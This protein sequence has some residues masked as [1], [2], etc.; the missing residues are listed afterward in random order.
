MNKLKIEYDIPKQ[1]DT[2]TF[3]EVDEALE[4]ALKPFGYKRWASGF[5]LNTRIRDLAFDKKG[6]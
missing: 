6:E 1:A 4:K 2:N 3:F 5:N